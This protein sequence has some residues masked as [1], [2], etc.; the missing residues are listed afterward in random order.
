MTAN[1]LIRELV[2][3]AEAARK[4]HESLFTQCLTNGVFTQWG[5]PVDCTALNEAGRLASY[6][7]I[8]KAHAYLETGGWTRVR[9]VKEHE[10]EALRKDAERYRWLRSR[11]LDT[12][13]KGGVFAG[14]TPRNIVLN[15]EHLDTA[16]DAALKEQSK[17]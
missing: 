11:D 1:E 5:Q 2:E 13:D 16:I 10:N 8:A 9:L 6:E 7:L 15:E 17:C 4:A 12:I 3:V 14:M